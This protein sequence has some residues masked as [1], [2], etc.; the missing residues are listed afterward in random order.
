[1]T[2]RSKKSKKHHKQASSKV[3][4]TASATPKKK[5]VITNANY[6]DIGLCQHIRNINIAKVK[7]VLQKCAKSKSINCV[8]CTK[9][10]KQQQ[11]SSSTDEEK[12][13]CCSTGEICCTN[14]SKTE[15]GAGGSSK[16][17]KSGGGKKNQQ[18]NIVL[19]LSDFTCYCYQCEC[20]VGFVSEL[21]RAHTSSNGMEYES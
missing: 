4:S 14:H 11:D 1:M 6:T 17:K 20:D 9:N 2:S 5:N 19:N 21:M 16:K 12:L 8:I 18:H 10:N 13:L 15:F 7:Q 3:A